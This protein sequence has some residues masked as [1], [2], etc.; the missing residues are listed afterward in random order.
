LG[1]KGR[2]IIIHYTFLCGKGNANHHLGTGF[3]IHNR[4]ILAVKRVEF[5]CNTTSY[6]TVKDRWWDIIVLNMH[7]PTEDKDDDI[8][9]SFYE[10][11]EQV[12]DE[13]CRYRM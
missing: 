4:I 9:E 5:V 10:E 8:K 13:F 2:D 6:I 7:A 1:G 11:L 3:F 12:F